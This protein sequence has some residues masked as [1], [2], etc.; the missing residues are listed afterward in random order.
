MGQEAAPNALR[1]SLKP[2]HTIWQARARIESR[3]GNRGKHG[4]RSRSEGRQAD[5]SRGDCQIPQLA[6]GVIM[7]AFDGGRL[8]TRDGLPCRQG[9]KS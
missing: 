3:T 1:D 2:E 5:L 6:E 9:T 7:H 8:A 4:V